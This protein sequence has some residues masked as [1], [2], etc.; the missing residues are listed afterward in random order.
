MLGI[1]FKGKRKKSVIGKVKEIIRIIKSY[2][3]RVR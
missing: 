2:K 3:I 1:N